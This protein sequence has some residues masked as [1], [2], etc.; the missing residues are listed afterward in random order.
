MDKA[1]PV[2]F[3]D[4]GIGG[5]PYYQWVRN[6]LPGVSYSYL[7]DRENFPYGQKAISE[8]VTIIPDV[9]ERYLAR[10]EP[11]LVVVACNTASVTA[12][13]QLRERFQVPFVGVVPAI[14]PAAVLSRKKSIGLLATRRTV[15][16]PY[17]DN[18][19]RLFAEGYQ[20]E[21][22]AGV[23]I[24]DFVENR[25]LDSE[26]EELDRIMAPAVRHFAER[27]IDTLVLGC[28]H[29]LHVKDS[30]VRSF[31]PDVQIVDSV[32]GVGRQVARLLERGGTRVTPEA[33]RSGS[34]T[35]FITGTTADEKMYRRF[36][37]SYGL[38]WG[39]R[40]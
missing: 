31:G 29:F 34:G 33:E 5:L 22:Y 2:A 11:G 27:E 7:A 10:V 26:R 40:L 37:E 12:L 39:G 38:D 6:L 14:K 36:A 1:G 8:L 32:E 18:L 19:V 24:V 9:M 23:D 15:D 16:D 28:T 30:I 4:S 25:L 13:Q 21:R 3:F 35:F 17:T 20:V